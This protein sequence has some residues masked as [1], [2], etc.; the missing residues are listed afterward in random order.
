M[1]ERLNEGGQLVQM[2]AGDDEPRRRSG[3]RNE[4]E[5]ALGSK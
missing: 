4:S 2:V 5:S 1:D 3:G